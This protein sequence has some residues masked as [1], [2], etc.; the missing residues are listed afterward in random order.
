MMSEKYWSSNVISIFLIPST[1]DK[2]SVKYLKSKRQRHKSSLIWN[3][4]KPR[5]T[6][7][8]PEYLY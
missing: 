7:L 8:K 5:K 2:L 3:I 1:C 4:F 6:F